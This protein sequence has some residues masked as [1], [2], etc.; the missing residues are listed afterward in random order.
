MKTFFKLFQL[1]LISISFWTL[2]YRCSIKSKYQNMVAETPLKKAVKTTIK[3]TRMGAKFCSINCNDVILNAYNVWVNEPFENVFKLIIIGYSRYT[4]CYFSTQWVTQGSFKYSNT[5]VF[6]LEVFV[7]KFTPSSFLQKTRFLWKKKKFK[8]LIL[9]KTLNFKHALMPPPFLLAKIIFFFKFHVYLLDV[10]RQFVL[11][12]PTL[13][14]MSKS[15]M[16]NCC[17]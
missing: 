4:G 16:L 1:I 17:K 8:T 6:L 11:S 9:F 2:S 5:N 7:T 15:Y 14:L 3:I 10:F 12:M 13:L